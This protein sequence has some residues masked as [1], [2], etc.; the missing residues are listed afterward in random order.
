MIALSVVIAQL[1]QDSDFHDSLIKV[2]LTVS[3]YMYSHCVL[4]IKRP[5][6]CCVCVEKEKKKISYIQSE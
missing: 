5:S 3:L 1:L 2:M 4:Y 6:S